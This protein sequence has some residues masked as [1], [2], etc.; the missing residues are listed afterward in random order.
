MYDVRAK[1][2]DALVMAGVSKEHIAEIRN[3][4]QIYGE[5]GILDSIG[6]VRLIGGVSLGFEDLGIDM[7]D[8]LESL[9]MEA[10]TAFSDMKSIVEFTERVLSEKMSEVGL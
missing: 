8:M 6:L 9:D 7:F 5:G 3:G 2:V 4:A 10:A 1:V